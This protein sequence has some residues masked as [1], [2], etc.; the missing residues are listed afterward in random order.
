MKLIVDTLWH[1]KYKQLC[2]VVKN[3]F[4]QFVMCSCLIYFNHVK[5]GGCCVWNH[6]TLSYFKI[7]KKFWHLY[8]NMNREYKNKVSSVNSKRLL[9]NWKNA[10]GDYFFAAPCKYNGQ[11]QDWTI[12]FRLRL[13]QYQQTYWNTTKTYLTSWQWRWVNIQR[14]AR[15]DHI[16]W[17]QTRLCR[18][19]IHAHTHTP[20]TYTP[21]PEKRGHGILGI[22]L[23]NLD[24]VS[25]FLA[26]IILI[27]QRSKTLE[28]LAQH[29]NIWR[30]QNCRLHY[31][32][33]RTFNKKLSERKTWHCKSVAKQI[34]EQKQESSLIKSLTETLM[35]NSVLFGSGR[36]PTWSCRHCS[37]QTASRS[38]GMSTHVGRRYTMYKRWFWVKLALITFI[39]TLLLLCSTQQYALTDFWLFFWNFVLFGV[40]V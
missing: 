37:D 26:Q 8:V 11:V 35:I 16:W 27:L 20:H 21:C 34:R 22:T 14:W 28:K 6:I 29:C 25:W 39:S 18:C 9:K 30:H 3:I 12:G 19:C 4:V 38:R 40:V 7:I 10:T 15:L 36:R 1:W 32:Q 2:F 31:T 17:C 23:T 33:R 24:T 5:T 13:L